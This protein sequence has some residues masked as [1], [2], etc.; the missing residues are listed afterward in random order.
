[1]Q[2]H[3]LP[4]ELGFYLQGTLVGETEASE[5]ADTQDEVPRETSASVYVVVN[6]DEC[7]IIDTGVGVRVL[8]A[9]MG[10]ISGRRLRP[11]WLIL[12]HDHYDHVGNAQ[13]FRNQVSAPLIAHALD[14]PLIEHPL[15]VFDDSFME[16]AYGGTLRQAFREMN[17]TPEDYQAY[18]QKVLSERFYPVKVDISC[19]D[20]DIFELGDLEVEIIHTPGH[21]PGSI[22]VYIPNEGVLFAGDVPLWFGPGRAYPLGDFRTWQDSMRRLLV[23]DT[24]FIGWGHSFP[25]SGRRKCQRFLRNTLRRAEEI[26]EVVLDEL[27]QSPQTIED[28]VDALYGDNLRVLE[29]H[30]NKAEE[31][32]HSLL[33]ALRMEGAVVNRTHD[34]RVYWVPNPS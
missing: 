32:L 16:A 31:S 21:T 3:S 12:T 5:S 24:E 4:N 18:Q 14:R 15:K 11:R 20:G 28:L 27:S 7:G 19:D 1:M 30:R 25:T 2:I 10:A 23:L 34:N 9:L 29:E 33:V 26:E 17:R 6:E 8:Q 22:S 13:G